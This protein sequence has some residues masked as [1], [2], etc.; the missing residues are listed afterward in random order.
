MIINLIFSEMSKEAAQTDPVTRF[1]QVLTTNN[2]KG[3]TMFLNFD[4]HSCHSCNEM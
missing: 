3:P 1:Q 2:E 4:S